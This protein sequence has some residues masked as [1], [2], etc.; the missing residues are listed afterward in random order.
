MKQINLFEDNFYDEE[1]EGMPEFIMT[2]EIPILTIKISFKS[3]E[4]VEEFSK[5]INQ[6]V[7]FNKENYW[8]PKL[9]RK[10]FSDYYYIDEEI[11]KK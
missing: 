4:D 5:L 3:K 6:K 1:W 8:Y 7:Q 10:A 9:N 2:P 11:Q